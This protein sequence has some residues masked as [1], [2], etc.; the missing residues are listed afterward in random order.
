MVHLCDSTARIDRR[1]QRRETDEPTSPSLFDN[2]DLLLFSMFESPP[3]DLASRLLRAPSPRE[4]PP[5]F[6]EISRRRAFCAFFAARDRRARRA[7][8]RASARRA[9]RATWRRRARTTAT[10]RRGCARAGRRTDAKTP[11]SR[12]RCGAWGS[13]RRASDGASAPRGRRRRRRRAMRERH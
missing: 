4:S 9:A 10:L 11:T 2:F 1:R 6:G 12:T 8:G 5:S 13:R 7:L 3:F